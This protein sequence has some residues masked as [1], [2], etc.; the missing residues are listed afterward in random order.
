MRAF[1]YAKLASW[2]LLRFY[3]V[4][5]YVLLIRVIH[6]TAAIAIIRFPA[7]L[8]TYL[9]TTTVQIPRVSTYCCVLVLGIVF[10]LKR[11]FE[12]LLCLTR[13]IMLQAMEKSY[14]SMCT[15]IKYTINVADE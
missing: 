1:N 2:Q 14:T 11:E 4:T 8:P 15:C 3:K 13:V 9:I 6:R 5:F 12:Q 10:I 7:C